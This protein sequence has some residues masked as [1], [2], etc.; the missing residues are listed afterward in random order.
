MKTTRSK[1]RGL[2]GT[3]SLVLPATGTKFCIS[4]AVFASDVYCFSCFGYD[5]DDPTK[6]Q[7][8]ES[9]ELFVR[10]CPTNSSGANPVCISY[11]ASYHIP[12]SMRG[13]VKRVTTEVHGVHCGTRQGCQKK[14]CPNFWPK[15]IVVEECKITCCESKDRDDC[16]F[17]LPSDQEIANYKEQNNGGVNN[18][19]AGARGSGV[20]R[21]VLSTW[22]QAL[23][24]AI[25]GWLKL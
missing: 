13:T 23:S 11:K 10:K 16:S 20:T 1:I 14:E 18:V 3:L 6:C 9:G 21:I 19:Q 8:R 24:F 22:L 25:F 7:S 17:P 12:Q 2:F 4:L 5:K 15:D